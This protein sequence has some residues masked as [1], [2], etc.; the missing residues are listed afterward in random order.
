MLNRSHITSLLS[1]PLEM[2]FFFQMLQSM[3]SL[4]A[5]FYSAHLWRFLET[6]WSPDHKNK[7]SWRRESRT[8]SFSIAACPRLAM[9]WLGFSRSHADFPGILS[10]CCSPDRSRFFLDLE[11]LPNGRT[12]PFRWI[13]LRISIYSK[14]ETVIW[15]HD[16]IGVGKK[17]DNLFL[18]H[19]VEHGKRNV[20]NNSNSS[21]L[22]S[23]LL[24]SEVDSQRFLDLRTPY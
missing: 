1:P 21:V 22:I 3:D 7:P 8:T 18:G 17:Q 19:I 2:P 16:D 10:G 9:K 13:R 14:N 24:I 6:N 15:V 20:D 5:V 23:S 11:H 4:K 12:Y